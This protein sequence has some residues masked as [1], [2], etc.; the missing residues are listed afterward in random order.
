MSPSYEEHSQATKNCQNLQTETLGRPCR[1][2]LPLT[3]ERENVELFIVVQIIVHVPE[4]GT[5]M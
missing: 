2:I 1:Q 5:I 4:A 3:R